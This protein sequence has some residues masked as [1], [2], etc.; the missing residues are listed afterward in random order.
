MMRRLFADQLSDFRIEFCELCE[1]FPDDLELALYRGAQHGIA[2]VVCERLPGGESQK[3][4]D[5]ALDIV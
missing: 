4:G 2:R 1:G 3:Q 5:G